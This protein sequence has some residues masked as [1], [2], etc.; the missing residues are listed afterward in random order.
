MTQFPALLQLL[1][2]SSKKSSSPLPLL[3]ILGDRR[4]RVLLLP[5]P[6]QAKA[7]A[8]RPAQGSGLRGGRRGADHRGRGG[9][10]PRDP[11]RPLHAAHREHRRTT[12]ASTGPSRPGSSSCARP[13]PA[14]SNPSSTRPR[15][16]L[17]DVESRITTRLKRREPGV[18]SSPEAAEAESADQRAGRRG[19][20]AGVVRRRLR[21]QMD[22]AT[23]PGPRRGPVRRLPDG[24]QRSRRPSST[25]RSTSSTTGSTASGCRVPRSARRATTRSRCPSPG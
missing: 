10:H 15:T 2:A 1:A 18:V 5:P 16:P 12:A 7:K 4:G 23:R 3:I 8:A 14:R 22:A 17:S 21:R 25:R 9:D 24:P 19:H 20:L 11:R 6:Q 13:S